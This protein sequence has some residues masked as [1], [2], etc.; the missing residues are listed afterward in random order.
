MQKVVLDNYILIFMFSIRSLIPP[1]VNDI[2]VLVFEG[3]EFYVILVC[4]LVLKCHVAVQSV[5]W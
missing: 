3:Y 5:I 4:N 1:D 2:L